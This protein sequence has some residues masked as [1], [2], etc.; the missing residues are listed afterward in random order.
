[1]AM[2]PEGLESQTLLEVGR[3][4]EM[5]KVALEGARRNLRPLSD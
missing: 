2:L 4:E 5:G 1:M 3:L